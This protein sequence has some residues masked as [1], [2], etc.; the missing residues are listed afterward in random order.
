MVHYKTNFDLMQHHKYSLNEIDMMM[1]WEK[2]VY[3][4][5]LVNYIKEENL[6]ME[7]QG[8]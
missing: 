7:T 4:N 8:R 1:P 5:M 2:E 3:V 6:K